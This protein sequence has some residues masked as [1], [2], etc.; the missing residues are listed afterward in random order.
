MFIILP[1]FP[2]QSRWISQHEKE[3]LL[4]RLREDRQEV[5]GGEQPLT[6]RRVF[7]VISVWY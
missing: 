5:G 1:D 2:E 3:I 4:R 7:Q 6:T